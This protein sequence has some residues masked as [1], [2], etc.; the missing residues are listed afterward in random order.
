MPV[1]LKLYD[2]NTVIKLCKINTDLNAYKNS[3]VI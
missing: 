1:N 2:Y 3:K